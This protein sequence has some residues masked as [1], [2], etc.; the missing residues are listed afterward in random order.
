MESTPGTSPIDLASWGALLPLGT[1]QLGQS[2]DSLITLQ[3]PAGDSVGASSVNVVAKYRP[4]SC[5]LDD[6]MV[7]A[8]VSFLDSEHIDEEIDYHVF[9]AKFV[10]CLDVARQHMSTEPPSML[11]AQ[12]ASR[13]L[14]DEMKVWLDTHADPM[15]Q[16]RSVTV[17]DHLQSSYRKVKFL[18]EDLSGQV[19]QAVSR[20]DWYRKWGR[21]FLP[22]LSRAHELQQCNNFKDPG[23]QH[24]GGK[25]FRAVRDRADDVFCSLPVPV[26]ARPVLSFAQIA[27][28]QAGRPVPA[29][30][31]VDVGMA[32][33]NDAENPC[34]HEDSLVAVFPGRGGESACIKIS[35]LR[36][37]DNLLGGGVVECIVKTYCKN[38]VAEVVDM[39]NGL[40]VTPYHP[41]KSSAGTWAFPIDICPSPPLLVPCTAIYSVVLN[42]DYANYQSLSINGH[43]V[44]ALGHDIQND[45]VASH[46]YLGRRTGHSVV[47]DLRECIGWSSDD[48]IVVFSSG[49]MQRQQV[50]SGSMSFTKTMINMLDY[51]K[52]I[53]T[54]P[55]TV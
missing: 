44:I 27:A 18:M 50:E 39:G 38:G 7:V 25:L 12:V 43:E 45:P 16:A 41:I 31:V 35:E 34:F 5:I 13:S 11:N 37:G 52:E 53:K 33:F 1:I 2:K 3:V 26:P 55:Y 14:L 19:T 51:D 21:H 49:C 24:F 47:S 22:S 48:G 20:I 9:R 36:K 29:S 17:D 4:T 42:S 40:L 32:A 23:I 8:P 6:E 54:V 28:A 10:H 46:P 30:A 15:G